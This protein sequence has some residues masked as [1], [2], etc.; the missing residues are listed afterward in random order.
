[1]QVQKLRHIVDAN[2]YAN[3]GLVLVCK[4]D[5]IDNAEQI[6]AEYLQTTG[7]DKSCIYNFLCG[8]PSG[9]VQQLLLTFYDY[10]PTIVIAL[11]SFG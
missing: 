9:I 7:L 3:Q 2:V 1:M 6:L 11:I 5:T 8:Q 10:W 4:V